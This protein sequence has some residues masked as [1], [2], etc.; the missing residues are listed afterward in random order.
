MR[1]ILSHAGTCPARCSFFDHPSQH[2]GSAIGGIADEAIWREVE[3][4]FDTLNHSPSR[5]DFGG[6]VPGGGLHISDHAVLSVDQVARGVGKECGVAWRCCPAGLRIGERHLFGI[7]GFEVLALGT[8]AER[9]ITP[10][11][12][13]T[14][15]PSLP[16]GIRFDD[17]ASTAKPS[18]LTR[19]AAM[20]R[21]ST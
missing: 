6:T 15:D 14:R 21:R 3:L 19:L 10:I 11:G 2:Q 5:I 17:A 18:P 9:C 20:Q 4:R 16:A 13:I 8:A 7:N 1:S 12:L